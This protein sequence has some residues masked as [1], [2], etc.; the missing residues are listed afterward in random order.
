MTTLRMPRASWLRAIAWRRMCI[1]G[2]VHGFDR[3]LEA[4]VSVRFT[5][6]LVGFVRRHL[7]SQP[8]GA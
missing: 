8:P 4:A 5:G 1:P 6:E 3:M 7:A 2:A